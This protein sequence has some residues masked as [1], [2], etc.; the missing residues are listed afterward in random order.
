RRPPRSRRGRST[1][2]PRR[3]RSRRSNGRSS[4]RR[5]L[6]QRPDGGEGSES[7]G[8]HY[9]VRRY[10]SVAP[11]P[12][13]PARLPLRCAAPGTGVRAT[14]TRHTPRD[15]TCGL[16][17]DVDATKDV[18]LTKLDQD[19]FAA[20]A[21]QRHPRV[22]QLAAVTYVLLSASRCRDVQTPTRTS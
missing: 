12:V 10:E 18:D 5:A 21:P 20:P 13:E 11:S 6:R 3:T 19:R 8:R 7:H 22:Y 14:G 2:R 17:R 16:V 9:R 1:A 4:G 15:L